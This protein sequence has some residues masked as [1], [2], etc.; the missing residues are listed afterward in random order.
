MKVRIRVLL[1]ARIVAEIKRRWESKTRSIVCQLSAFRFRR[2]FAADS[3]GTQE[4]NE[5]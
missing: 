4:K 1:S 5:K 3:D 2:I